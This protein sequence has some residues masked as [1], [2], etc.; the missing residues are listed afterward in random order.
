MATDRMTRVYH[1]KQGF[2]S[3]P[4]HPDWF[5]SLPM[6]LS[7]GLFLQV[8]CG[9]SIMLIAHPHLVLGW[10]MCLFL[11]GLLKNRDRFVCFLLGKFPA[12]EFYMPT[13]RNTLSVP[14]RQIVMKCQ[15]IKLRCRGITQ[16]KAYNIQ[17]M[18]IVWNQGT[19]LPILIRNFL[20]IFFV[21]SCGQSHLPFFFML[22]SNQLHS[23][24]L[25][26]HK[27]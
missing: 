22:T 11:Y 23:S 13:F 4:S 10:R 26:S 25:L 19:V 3:L 9:E 16:K 21:F 14:N 27:S 12:F 18:A 7:N 5:W 6:L 15:H 8:K 1:Q 20:W 2:L 17:N 24:H